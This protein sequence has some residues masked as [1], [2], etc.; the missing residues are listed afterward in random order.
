MVDCTPAYDK[1]RLCA[2]EVLDSMFP[3]AIRSITAVTMIAMFAYTF[4]AFYVDWVTRCEIRIRRQIERAAI[5][6]A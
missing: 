6:D 3:E 4:T 5:D 1:M 2:A